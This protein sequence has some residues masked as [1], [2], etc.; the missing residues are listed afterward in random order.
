MSRYPFRYDYI[1]A[2][3]AQHILRQIRAPVVRDGSPLLGS[4][5]NGDRDLCTAILGGADVGPGMAYLAA[6]D[7]HARLC[8]NLHI[9]CILR[10]EECSCSRYELNTR[11]LCDGDPISI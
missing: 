8:T 9:A 6:L 2:S 1:M 5:G 3:E 7:V 11:Y 10:L 4:G